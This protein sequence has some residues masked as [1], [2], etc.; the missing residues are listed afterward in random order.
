LAYLRMHRASVDR[1]RGRL[2]LLNGRGLQ[3][4]DRICLE[5]GFAAGGTEVIGPAFALIAMFCGSRVD[6]HPADGIDG[7]KAAVLTGARLNWM[8]PVVAVIVG[9]VAVGMRGIRGHGHERPSV[10]YPMGV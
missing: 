2:F 7:L 3:I 4:L 1:A 9:G 10:N 8:M 5:L 6:R